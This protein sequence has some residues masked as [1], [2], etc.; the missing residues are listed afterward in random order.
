MKRRLLSIALIASTLFASFTA[1]AAEPSGYYSSAV[2]KNKGALLSA[3]EKIVGSH[4]VVSYDGLWEMFKTT[5][6][7]ADGKVWDMYSTAN[8]TFGT[9]KCG[10]YSNMGDCYNREHSF[11]KSWFNDATP[12][13]SDGFHLYPTDGKVNSQRSNYPFGECANGTRLAPVKGV[14]AK[15][16][17]GACTFPGYT[18][19]VF[20]PDDEYKGD[21]ARSYFY[22]AAAYNGRIANWN[23][24][25][26]AKNSYP[27]Y[28]NW[29]INLLLKWHRQDPV[30]QKEIDR[31]EGVYGFQKNR[32]PFIDHPELAEYIWGN[33]MDKGWVPGG[34]P[35]EPTIYSPIKDEMYDLGDVGTGFS[36]STKVNVKG[37]NFEDDITVSV[38]N[39]TYFSVTP[40]S[41]TP[42]ALSQGVNVTVTFKGAATAGVYESN[43]I[44][45]G[46]DQSVTAKV[47]AT[48]VK[49]VPVLPA[50]NVDFDRFTINW[51]N[52]GGDVYSVFVYE[53]DGTTVLPGYPKYV[54]PGDEHLE[55]TGVNYL[56]TYKYAI[57]DGTNM[58]E[59]LSVTTLAPTR[60]LYPI[61][62]EGALNFKAVPGQP[63]ESVKVKIYT[64][65]IDDDITVEV[66]EHFQ[67]S[68]DNE[69]WASK[70]VI[71]K[72]GED[73][74]VRGAAVSD[75]CVLLGTMT[76]NT[77][78]FEGEDAD[79]KLT[80]KAPRAFFEDWEEADAVT[81][82]SYYTGRVRGTQCMWNFKDVL[83][84]GTDGMNG[85]LSARTGKQSDDMIE[86]AEDKQNGAGH[87]SFL[88]KPFG[89][90]GTAVV[91]IYYSQDGGQSWSL[92]TSATIS[93]SKVTE[94]NF[95]V[96]KEGAIR[97]RLQQTS[98]K[99]FCI[100]DIDISDYNTEGVDGVKVDVANWSAVA[101]AG[102][103]KVKAESACNVIVYNTDATVV[104]NVQMNG[105]EQFIEL[106]KGVYIVTLDNDRGT[107]VVVR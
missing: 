83:L 88:A 62:N 30:S 8:F 22:M 18:K 57:S 14:E 53:A 36:K 15:G 34:G 16:K 3:L 28:A 64:E 46:D 60:I 54:D 70:I 40:S 75:E 39:P 43:L 99:R 91:D 52:V 41:I 77:P 6:K 79:M 82:K 4:T 61:F 76:L 89:S 65:Y 100:D 9:N 26:L 5:D 98:G 19:T 25:M 38:S 81:A 47:K 48:V 71:D 51:T 95:E 7:R 21:F 74:Y 103:V 24:D 72:E 27:A 12:M 104:S 33:M 96:N 59:Q 94:Y 86:M 93:N 55:V 78:T 84:I 92:L 32:N 66:S 35:T 107:K 31:N 49:G 90:D 45:A 44:V 73:I 101:V 50:T 105:G 37:D 11:P 85:S 20:E 10:S 68:R 23:C 97:F 42:S 63:S 2:G 56:T 1:T 17:L 87:I 106:P 69:T 80:V 102:G 58:S 29:A 67:V 13:Y